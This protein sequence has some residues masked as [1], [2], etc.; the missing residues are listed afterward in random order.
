MATPVTENEWKNPHRWLIVFLVVLTSI[1]HYFCNQLPSSLEKFF[2]DKSSTGYQYNKRQ[3]ATLYS[4]TFY[5]AAISSIIGGLVCDKYGIARSRV[6]FYLIATIGQLVVSIGCLFRYYEIMLIGR[7]IYGITSEAYQVSCMALITKYFVNAELFFGWTCCVSIGRI[8]TSTAYKISPILMVTF[9][10]ILN[11]DIHDSITGIMFAGSIVMI[12][13]VVASIVVLV[14]DNSYYND[15]PKES[16]KEPSSSKS[17]VYDQVFAGLTE[18]SSTYWIL[19]LLVIPSMY[20]VTKGWL[21]LAPQYLST[22]F[23]FDAQKAGDYAA[24][25]ALLPAL[26]GPI[27]AYFVDLKGNRAY[28]LI[29]AGVILTIG[30]IMFCIASTTELCKISTFILSIGY[31]IP[32]SVVWPCIRFVV[33]KQEYIG[34]AVGIGVGMVALGLA[35]I[36]PFIGCLVDLDDGYYENA[37]IVWIS[38]VSLG[39][40]STIWLAFNDNNHN[41]VLFD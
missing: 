5:P 28:W 9:Q 1:G 25:V 11:N 41:R 40:F 38:I 23:G 39:L 12:I 4:I 2:Q 15:N 35:I 34:K 26:F 29:S 31:S 24:T 21:V 37:E 16:N 33:E 30:Q 3:T 14:I 7:F 20:L 17:I 27:F 32:P 18:F 22:R 8:T 6:Y 10:S 19:V 36:P 13:G